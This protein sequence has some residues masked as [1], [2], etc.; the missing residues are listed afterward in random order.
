MA[1]RITTIE[2]LSPGP[3]ELT[4]LQD[5]FCETHGLQCGYCTPGM[6]LAG[7]ALLARTLDAHARRDRRGHLRQH[8]PLHRLRPDRRGD[9]ARRRAPARR[10]PEAGRGVSMGETA[11]LQVRLAQAP[12]A[13]GS[14]LRQRP[15]D[16]RQRCDAAGHPARRGADLA[17]R[18]RPH[19]RHRCVRGA[20]DAGRASGGRRARSWRPRPTR[21]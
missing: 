3:G 19:R 2:G 15:G 5:A 1:T 13:R 16:V 12:G 9:R 21:C 14:P 17:L 7:H 4:V 8:L 18:L 6:I 20:G 10:Q 11:C